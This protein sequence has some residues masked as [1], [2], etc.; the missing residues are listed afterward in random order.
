MEY[1]DICVLCREVIDKNDIMTIK[2]GC[3]HIYHSDHIKECIL[4]NYLHCLIC[5]RQIFSGTDTTKIKSLFNLY[6]LSHCVLY[7]PILLFFHIYEKIIVPFSK[8]I[9]CSL[10]IIVSAMPILLFFALFDVCYIIYCI[11]LY[12]K[13]HVYQDQD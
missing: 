10:I 9:L 4:I 3:G 5:R 1:N 11:T 12:F 8:N 7:I 6:D 2:Y 13:H